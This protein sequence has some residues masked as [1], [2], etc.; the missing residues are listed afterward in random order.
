MSKLSPKAPSTEHTVPPRICYTAKQ[1]WIKSSTVQIGR[2][3]YCALIGCCSRQLGLLPLVHT[4]YMDAYTV[5]NTGC[6]LAFQGRMYHPFST[7]YTLPSHTWS[8]AEQRWIKSCTVQTSPLLLV[9]LW[10]DPSAISYLCSTKSCPA[11][12]FT[13]NVFWLSLMIKNNAFKTW[14]LCYEQ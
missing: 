1:R 9:G 4:L 7:A 2:W 14:L 11:I 12:R 13:C 3:R 6:V 8:S 10:E 5:V